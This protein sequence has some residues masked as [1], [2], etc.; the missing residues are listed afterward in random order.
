VLA[1][2]LA[3][4]GGPAIAAEVAFVLPISHGRVPENMRRIRVRQHDL[5]KLHWTSDVPINIHLHGYDIEKAVSP[6]VVTE[7]GFVARVAGR[8]TVESHVGKAAAGG[9]G[10]GNVLVTIEVYP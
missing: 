6:G 9:H 3:G 1:L 7:M 10:H 5:V 8:F 2:S 4:P